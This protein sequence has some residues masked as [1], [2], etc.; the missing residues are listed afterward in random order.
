MRFFNSRVIWILLIYFSLVPNLSKASHTLGGEI[1]WECLNDGRFVFYA[2]IYRDCTG[3]QYPFQDQT[4]NIIGNPLPRDSNNV[5]LSSITIKPDSIEWLAQNMG[6]ISPD[7]NDIGGV[8]IKCSWRDNGSYQVLPY[9]SDPI[10]LKGVPPS[11]GWRFANFLP[12]CRANIANLAASGTQLLSAIMY[13]NSQLNTVDDCYNSSPRFAEKIDYYSCR[14]VLKNANNAA[15][16][17]E[18]DSLVYSFEKT[19]NATPNLPTPVPYAGGYDFDN[20]TP[21]QNFNPMNIPSTLDPQNGNLSYLVRSGSPL[22]LDYYVVVRVDEYR[23]NTLLSSTFRE[24]PIF[25]TDCSDGASSSKLVVNAFEDNNSITV[26]ESIPTY[27]VKI[28]VGS[29]M[30]LD[31]RSYLID[32]LGLISNANS[33]FSISSGQFS[34]SVNDSSLCGTPPCAEYQNFRASFDSLSQSFV[35]STHYGNLGTIVWNTDCQHIDSALSNNT[36]QFNIQR[37]TQLCDSVEVLNEVI[38]V[39]IINGHNIAP[40]IECLTASNNNNFIVSWNTNGVNRNQFLYWSIYNS[41][42]NGQFELLDTIQVFDNYSTG[43]SKGYLRP[44]SGYFPE[45]FMKVNMLNCG[46]DGQGPPSDTLSKFGTISQVGNQLVV[47][48]SQATNLYTFIW[49]E[50]DPITGQRDPS[51]WVNGGNPY[52]PPDS[53]YY[54]A[55]FSGGGPPFCY[56]LTDCIYYRR[57]VSLD[58]L[59]LDDL[60]KLYPNPS[61]GIVNIDREV[62][63]P[64]DYQI[65]NIQGKLMKS[66]SLAADENQIE[67]PQAEGLYFV[68]FRDEGGNEKTYKLL[69]K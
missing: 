67:L 69:K 48:S 33:D 57:T 27:T 8:V 30:R 54:S 32:S 6:D 63:F 17:Q 35:G 3:I 36:Y 60:L 49:G 59:Q 61:K 56:D 65:F 1:W 18:N 19:Y 20:P 12:C 13:P 28:K 22:S 52:T 5:S 44:D 62:N 45:V 37:T 38:N 23:A 41:R 68:S 58:E 53:G 66:G 55:S 16:D 43:N 10:R 14:G 50:C 64:L 42:S 25:M 2:K 34:S 15:I 39:E 11:T 51:T 47:Q 31:L 29:E 7:C 46:A 26:Q 21:D 24:Y 9:K 4:L 40:E